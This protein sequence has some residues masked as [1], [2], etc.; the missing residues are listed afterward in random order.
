MNQQGNQYAF[1]RT[2]ILVSTFG[3]LL[4]GYD[5]GVINGALPYMSEADQLN[6]NSFTQG[7]VA[8]SLLFGAALGAVLGGRLSD[9]YGRRRNILYLAVL[10]FIATLGCT[11]APNITVMIIFRF[12]LGLA[13]GG[14]SVT[15]PTFLAEMSPAERRG[16][17]VTQNE[18]MIVSGQLLAFVFNAI[19]GN[20]MGD[21][22]HVW[23]YMLAIA[24][25]PAIF[26]FFGMLKVPES[27]RWL[28]S[29]GKNEDAKR[30]LK[31]IREEKQAKSEFLEI[32][33]AL[34]KESEIKKATIKDF[35]VPWVRRI[36]FL[37]IGIAFVQQVTGVNSIMYY[38]SEI[39][40]DAGFQ[41][42]AALIGN[43][44]NG[45]ISVA[46]TFVGIWLLGKVG[47]RKMLLTGQI[48]VTMA[49]LL[50][51]IFSLTLEGSAALPYVVLTLT[52][53]FL[54]FMQGAIAPVTW[55]MLS[56]IFPLRLRGFGMGVSVF[57]LWIVNFLIGLVFP[58]ALS[59]LGL[60]MTFFTFVALNLLAIAFVVKFLPETKGRTLEQLEH[61]FRTYKVQADE[62]I[63]NKADVPVK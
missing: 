35:T 7:L 25:L 28:V 24:S 44:A 21:N 36:L 38:G 54:A 13:V 3:G 60:T 19:L 2:I 58:M 27:P 12:L 18:L 56:E 51:A 1:L 49:L 32:Q 39:L 40:K 15:V 42:E 59:Y 4:F 33:T 29:K 45:A 50:I 52:V 48:G 43:I 63:L 55:L 34:A 17:M 14:A 8:S 16:R 37:G 46:A 61:Y 20:T 47:R 9:Y 62:E 41:T 5:T 57:C 31:L 26:L 10:F 6:L 30:V 53:T 22:S 11:L 23:R